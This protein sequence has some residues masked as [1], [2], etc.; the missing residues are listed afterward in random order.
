[1]SREKLKFDS[2]FILLKKF[3]L[4]DRRNLNY[5]AN[6]ITLLLQDFTDVVMNF[7]NFFDR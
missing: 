5:L 1:M 4:K 2:G 3:L 6:V 7:L